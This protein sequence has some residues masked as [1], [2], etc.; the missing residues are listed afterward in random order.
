ME[1]LIVLGFIAVTAAVLI[2][3]NLKE[4]SIKVEDTP[5]NKPIPEKRVFPIILGSTFNSEEELFGAKAVVFVDGKYKITLGQA[6][7]AK[8]IVGKHGEYGGMLSIYAVCN[9]IKEKV[10]KN[11]TKSDTK[12]LLSFSGKF[13][14]IKADECENIGFLIER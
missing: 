12:Y 4:K 9:G 6:N 8:C 11:Y 7:P 14:T 3:V 10:V 2:I 5:G 13:S 1:L